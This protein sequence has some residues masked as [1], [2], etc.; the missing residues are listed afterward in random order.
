[1]AA[2]KNL[3]FLKRCIAG[4]R[5]VNFADR[6]SGRVYLRIESGTPILKDPAALELAV[7]VPDAL[8]ALRA[9]APEALT[10]KVPAAQ[11]AQYLQTQDGVGSL[12]TLGQW[13]LDA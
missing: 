4:F 1:L 2:E 6:D 11:Q 12:Q 10:D 5:R 13:G 7:R 9:V 3:D 8:A